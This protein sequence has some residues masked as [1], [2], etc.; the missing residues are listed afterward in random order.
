MPY[1]IKQDLDVAG[2]GTFSGNVSVPDGTTSGHAINKGQFDTAINDIRNK[3]DSKPSVRAR[4]TSGELHS[5]LPYTTNS[6]V[7]LELGDRVLFASGSSTTNS[8]P[9]IVG[10]G[11]WVRADDGSITNQ[12]NWR[13]EEGSDAGIAYVVTTSG[14]VVLGTTPFTIVPIAAAASLVADSNGSTEIV[15]DEIRVKIAP[16]GTQSTVRLAVDASGVYIVDVDVAATSNFYNDDSVVTL[17]TVNVDI[18]PGNV[19]G[20]IGGLS[21]ALVSFING[22]PQYGTPKVFLA[23]QTD[24]LE[25]G[26]YYWANASGDAPTFSSKTGARSVIQGTYVGEVWFWD[27]FSSSSSI[28]RISSPIYFQTISAGIAA[29]HTITHNKRTTR[30]QVKLFDTVTNEEIYAQPSNISLNA[31]DLVLSA[32][33]NN[34]QVVVNITPD[35]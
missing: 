16:D 30:P 26:V 17:S 7:D 1:R 35:A 18:S 13:V 12:S 3:D 24:P 28:K 25:N 34:V 10:T 33:A 23:G 6:G 11:T 14:D 29:T 21:V 8:G 32:L 15:S 2:T 19:P 20:I 9:Y 5:A 31:F 4:I 27:G 22:I